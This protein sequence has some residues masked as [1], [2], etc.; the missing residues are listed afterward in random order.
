[1]LLIILR[2]LVNL[3]FDKDFH[4]HVIDNLEEQDCVGGKAKLQSPG[5]SLD[6]PQFSCLDS[7]VPSK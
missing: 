1:M 2:L 4:D 3:P 7:E 6:I 5:L